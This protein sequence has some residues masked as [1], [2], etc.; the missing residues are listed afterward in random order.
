MGSG[1]ALMW[2]VVPMRIRLTAKLAEVVDG[3]DLSHCVEGNVI[4][5][6]ERQAHLLMREGWAEP[7]HEGEERADVRSARSS[8]QHDILS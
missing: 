3:I 5:L 6:S 8:G 7:A 1:V 4:E 2:S